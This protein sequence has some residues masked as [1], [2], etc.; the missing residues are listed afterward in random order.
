MTNAPTLNSDQKEAFEG[1]K[2]F[3]QHPTSDTFVLKGYAGTGKTFLMQYLAK[4]LK[5]TDQDFK[6]LASTGRAASVLRGKTGFEAKTV[7]GI[8]YKFSKVDG[9]YDHI[10]DDA[11]IDK[12]GQMTLQFTLKPP[13]PKPTIYIVDEASML[14]SEIPETNNFA[15]F[16]SGMLL[17]DFFEFSSKNKIIFVGDPCQLPPVGQSFSPALDIPWLIEHGRKPIEFT[18]QKI[19][20]TRADNDLL[21]LAH[22]IRDY[23][24][25]INPPK[26]PKIPAK[27][28]N[29]VITYKNEE[30]L[31]ESY[32][33]C[34]SEN[35]S[36]NALAIAR[37]NKMVRSINDETRFSMYGEQQRD[38]EVGE[39]LLV[40]QNNFAIP[41]TNGDFVIVTELGE[42]KQKD[43]LTFRKVRI[44]T[45][46]SD[47]EYDILLS[48]NIL[49]ESENGNFTKEQNKFLM[50]DFSKRM[51]NDGNK[52]ND[53]D[54]MKEM[55]SDPY[56]NCLKASYGY[57]VTCH[58]SQGGEWGDVFLFLEGGMYGM[59][60]QEL[61]RW[62]YTAI[63]RAK[64][65]VHLH[66]K[67]WITY[68]NEDK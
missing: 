25:L 53:E 48:L 44:K 23:T 51:R 34:V 1:I 54:Y 28:L 60:K 37:T 4:W 19:E 47:Q 64:K 61:F 2:A 8:V 33:K 5:A 43:R 7:H 38:I 41:V 21:K 68:F 52:P 10:P 26:Y 39:T 30:E 27:G 12:F 9:D 20:R 45:L 59:K 46:L 31:L 67:W 22:K 18:L 55:M 50:V 14:S 32:R 6:L 58:K 56:L 29:M 42:I 62:W 36:L 57:G 11:P 35:G 65:H 17:L 49:Y 3:L 15:V 40:T 16:G 63:T 13:D 24:D 66:D